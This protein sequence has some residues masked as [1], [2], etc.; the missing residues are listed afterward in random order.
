M[1]AK[2]MTEHEAT[3]FVRTKRDE[4]RWT[5]ER[6]AETLTTKGYRSLRTGE[7]VTVSTVRNY[8]YYG[9]NPRKPT[10]RRSKIKN[11]TQSVEAD[12]EIK[13]KLELLK[14]IVDTPT[15]D[16]NIVK[17]VKQVLKDL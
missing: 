14:S 8:Y 11:V 17:L 4:E 6:I 16:A 5:W 12:S 15:S 10:P 7:P 9:P 2:A 13:S 3:Q 1:M